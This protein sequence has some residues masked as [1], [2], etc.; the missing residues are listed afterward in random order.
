LKRWRKFSYMKKFLLFLLG[1]LLLPLCVAMTGTVI[2]VLRDAD[3]QGSMFSVESGCIAVGFFAWLICWF[4]L[5]QPVRIYILGHELTHALWAI[6]F[7]GKAKNLSI[8]ASGGS[9]KVTKSNV[10]ITLAPYFFPFYTMVLVGILLLVKLFITPLPYPWIWLFLLGFT[11]S[12]HFTFTLQSLWTSQ[13]DIQ[14]YGRLFSYSLIYLLNVVGIALWIVFSMSVSPRVLGVS[15]LSRTTHVY[16][17]TSFA[18]V[19]G[20]KR[21]VEAIRTR[22]SEAETIRRMPKAKR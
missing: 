6:L 8:K 3:S 16:Y 18:L 11:W 19:D 4:F 17:K 2:D 13:P 5:P 21:G 9:V 22:W 10:W 12:F 15:W 7:G 1:I 14:E 20:V